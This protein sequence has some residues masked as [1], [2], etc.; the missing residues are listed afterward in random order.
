MFSL[1]NSIIVQTHAKSRDTPFISWP[2][3]TCIEGENKKFAGYRLLGFGSHMA[4]NGTKEDEIK[5]TGPQYCVMRIS[6]KIV[7]D[8]DKEIQECIVKGENVMI[9]IVVFS[10]IQ[11]KKSIEEY[12][13]VIERSWQMKI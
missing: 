2:T 12:R 11:I 6:L 10:Q 7:Q 4:A 13:M 5:C 1:E 3:N 8:R 9:G